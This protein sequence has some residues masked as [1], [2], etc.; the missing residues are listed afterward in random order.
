MSVKKLVSFLVSRKMIS[1]KKMA[2]VIKN[3][4]AKKEGV[5]NYLVNN[6]LIDSRNFMLEAARLLRL[7][8][9]DLNA[10]NVSKA[11]EKSIN[12]EKMLELNCFTLFDDSKNTYVAVANPLDNQS[13]IREYRYTTKHHPVLIVAEQEKIIKLIND[14]KNKAAESGVSIDD[15]KSSP[16]DNIMGLMDDMAAEFDILEY[17]QEEDLISTNEEEQAPIIKLV[18]NTVVDGIQKG[19][20]DIHFEP[21]EDLYRIR[22]RIDGVLQT[23]YKLSTSLSAKISAR[24][25]IMSNLDIAEKRIPQDGKFKIAISKDKQIDFRVSVCPI[26]FGEK[27]VLRIIDKSSTQIGV[28]MLG[29]DSNQEKIFTETLDMPQGMILVTGPTGSGKTVTLYTGLDI[30]NSPEKNISTA[31]DP[32]EV[33]ITGINQVHINNKQGLSFAATLKSFLRQDPDI[34]M[35]G[36]IRDLETAEIAFKASQT[37]HLVLSTLHTN[38]AA[39]TLNRLVDMG[40]PKYN[41]ATSVSLIIAQRLGRKLCPV[42]KQVENSMILDDII[43]EA[44]FTQEILEAEGI[45]K[46]KVKETIIYKPNPNGCSK[47]FKG[48]KGRIGLYEVMP[49]VKNIAKMILEDRNTVDIADQAILNGV[50]NIRQSAIIKVMQGITSLQEAYRV[51]KG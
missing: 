43:N 12:I 11:P 2:D 22:F 5:F 19:A 29:F 25:K 6:N 34:I 48:Y 44:H 3:E 7:K 14:L 27:I 10:Y 30:L 51:T 33:N 4:D 8:Y 1:N 41:I 47:C 15:L 9:I 40:L 38:S 24:L 20:S 21:Y 28:K 23:V 26:A 31:E 13:I 49:V 16:E 39:E 32:V 36:E 18:N 46:E 17:D 35:V 37:G 50:K 45:T 42:C